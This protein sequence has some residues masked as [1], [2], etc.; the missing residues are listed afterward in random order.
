MNPLNEIN[1]EYAKEKFNTLLSIIPIETI[2]FL[3]KVT[4]VYCLTYYLEDQLIIAIVA[5]FSNRTY[6]ILATSTTTIRFNLFK[7][8]NITEER[9]L[10]EETYRHLREQIILDGIRNNVIKQVP[11]SLTDTKIE[12]FK[13]EGILI[14]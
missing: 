1:R 14:C 4:N 11:N 5:R 10:F 8:K 2:G 3:N 7:G 9:M 6:S 13:K 12:S